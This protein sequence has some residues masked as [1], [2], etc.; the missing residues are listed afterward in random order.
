MILSIHT[1][2]LSSLFYAA[3]LMSTPLLVSLA[4]PDRLERDA[5][6]LYL[7]S[8]AG[9]HFGEPRASG[10][11][12]NM[13]WHFD[14]KSVTVVVATLEK[15]IEELTTAERL[16]LVD[17]LVDRLDDRV[18]RSG[19]LRGLVDTAGKCGASA[20]EVE[21]LDGYARAAGM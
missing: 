8:F 2:S 5:K 11:Q 15:N 19:L 9:P 13:A 18:P 17:D 21:E 4:L 7:R 10:A 12:N 16:E 20:A 1:Y 3:G 14:A 6:Q